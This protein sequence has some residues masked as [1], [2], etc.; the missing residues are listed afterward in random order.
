MH[1][2]SI[3][4]DSKLT[5]KEHKSFKF[6]KHRTLFIV[7]IIL[8][9]IYIIFS[10]LFTVIEV[11][12]NS[13]APTLYNGEFLISRNIFSSLS[14]FDV[15]IYVDDNQI[16][17]IKRVIGLP[18]ETIEYKNNLLYVNGEL[19][20]ESYSVGDTEDFIEQLGDKCYYCLGDNRN[21]SR[22]SRVI[23]QI[24]RKN[25]IAKVII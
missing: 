22:D 13:M 20:I 23:G 8:L 3:I 21:D 7:A 16:P 6:T 10:L 17:T 12:G 18:G 24:P 1:S 15:V 19:I 9:A 11:D 14:R 4:E 5:I 2:N 25:I